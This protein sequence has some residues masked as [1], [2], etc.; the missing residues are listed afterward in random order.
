MTLRLCSDLT[1]ADWIATSDVDWHH[2]LTFGP[3]G[4]A[5][6]AR[7]RFIPD[8]VRPG[9]QEA[10][11]EGPAGDLTDTEKMGFALE[12]LARHTTTPEDCYFALW[13]GWGDAFPAPKVLLP[14]REFFL[15]RGPLTSYGDDGVRDDLQPP[16]FVWP[17]DHAWCL[18]ADVDPHWA[19]VGASAAAVADLLTDT[20]VDV[21][22]ADPAAVQPFYY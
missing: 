8:P 18:T 12:T 3:G 21:V 9:Q 2:L 5:A 11:Y 1:A 19:G 20:R 7:L 13:D 16:A 14:E 6:Y 10:D 4:F 22:R 17:A 15:F